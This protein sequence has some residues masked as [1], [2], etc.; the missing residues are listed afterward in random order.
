MPKRGER[1]VWRVVDGAEILGEERYAR[2]VELGDRGM[3]GERLSEEEMEEYL[4]LAREMDAVV[5]AQM[6]DGS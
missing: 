5:F 3:A 1:G 6:E 4:S 2:M